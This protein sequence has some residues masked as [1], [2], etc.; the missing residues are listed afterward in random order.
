M[1]SARLLISST[2]TIL[3]SILAY[4]VNI[5]SL[6]LDHVRGSRKTIH[7]RKRQEKKGHRPDAELF[8]KWY[9]FIVA[10]MASFIEIDW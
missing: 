9:G 2:P 6:P 4:K 10:V 5:H 1:K 3:R 8:I 7:G